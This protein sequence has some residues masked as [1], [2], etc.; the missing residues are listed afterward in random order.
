M[1]AAD[2]DGING[3][4]PRLFRGNALHSRLAVSMSLSCPIDNA[5]GGNF[6]PS[7]ARMILVANDD[8][9]REA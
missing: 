2:S 3:C 5:A 4:P 9:P 1:L 8:M 6:R 7:A